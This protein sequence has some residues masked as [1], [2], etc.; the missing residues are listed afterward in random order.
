MDGALMFRER[1]A[2]A[3]E[4]ARK[5]RLEGVTPPHSQAKEEVVPPTH[6]PPR[7]TVSLS[8]EGRYVN[9]PL[10]SMGLGCGRMEQREEQ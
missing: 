9:A 10:K 3:T 8:R 7:V 2:L 5:L 1:E 6:L 4:S